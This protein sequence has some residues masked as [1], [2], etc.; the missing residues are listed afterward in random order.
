MT[1]NL[2]GHFPPP[3]VQPPTPADVPAKKKFHHDDGDDDDNV[4][5]EE[6]SD[7]LVFCVIWKRPLASLAI[8]ELPL[9]Q[10]Q[11]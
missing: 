3:F 7:S 10:S 4:E 6:E 2:L 5:E 1:K 11:L 8:G 9:Q